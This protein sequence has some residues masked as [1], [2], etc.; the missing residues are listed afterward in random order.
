MKHYFSKF[1]NSFINFISNLKYELLK[2]SSSYHVIIKNN[3][4]KDSKNWFLIT[5]GN[6]FLSP[7]VAKINLQ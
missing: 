7:S 5:L 1:L 6:N 4:L 3:Y 2:F